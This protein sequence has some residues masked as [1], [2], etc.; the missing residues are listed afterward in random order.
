MGK[1]VEEEIG[2]DFHDVCCSLL[3]EVGSLT[4]HTNNRIVYIILIESHSNWFIK[5][6]L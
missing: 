3:D 4:K 1:S 6:F 2:K 5:M